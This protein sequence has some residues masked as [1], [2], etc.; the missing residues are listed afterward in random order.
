MIYEVQF[1][2]VIATLEQADIPVKGLFLNADAGF[3]SKEFRKSCDKKEVN[4]NICLN[5][6]NGN[7]DRNGYFDKGL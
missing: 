5:K 7:G 1:E 2:V 3:D 6:R 4:V